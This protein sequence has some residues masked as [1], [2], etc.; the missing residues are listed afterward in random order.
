MPSG[1]DTQTYQ[2]GPYVGTKVISRNYVFHVKF[3][4]KLKDVKMLCI[5]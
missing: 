2:Y 1:V 4:K 5:F 3:Q